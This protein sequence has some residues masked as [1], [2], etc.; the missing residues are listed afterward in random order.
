MKINNS[1]TG[2]SSGITQPGASTG[3]QNNGLNFGAGQNGTDISQL[4]AGQ[5][6]RGE[7]IDIRNGE[8]VIKIN[9]TF[10]SARFEESVN[11]AIGD[12]LNFIVRDNNNNKVVIAPYKTGGSIFYDTLDK[13]L[14]AANLPSTDRNVEV[15]ANL[16]KHQMPVDKKTITAV[17]AK[18]VR[19]PQTDPENIVLMKKFNLEVTKENLTQFQNYRTGQKSISGQMEQFINKLAEGMENLNT[20][21]EKISFGKFLKENFE[22]LFKQE[23][24]FLETVSGLLRGELKKDKIPVL[25]EVFR[26]ALQKEWSLLPEQFQKDSLHG[27]YE[28][29]YEQLEHVEKHMGQGAETNTGKE[30]LESAKNIKENINFMNQLN[31]QFIY[32]QI[33]LSFGKKFTHGELYVFKRRKSVLSKKD[34]VSVLLHL[35]MEHMG[36]MD[37]WLQ[38]AEKKAYGRFTVQDKESADILKEHMEELNTKLSAMGYAFEADTQVNREEKEID[39]VEDFLEKDEGKIDLKRYSFDMR[40]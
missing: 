23:S 20:E 7:V 22:F 24:G 2:L 25:K 30:L 18:A 17:L 36:N 34:G 39:F 21:Q 6:F 35:D 29:L 40:A 12:I 5:V 9:E 31:E 1:S 19:Y 14:E 28:R 16:I 32:S 4:N 27:L 38:C 3:V 8:A 15:V 37:I 33:P 10:L 13:A 11:L 26:N